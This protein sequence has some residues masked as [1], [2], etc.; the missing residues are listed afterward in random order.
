MALT[1][2]T[3]MTS[4]ILSATILIAVAVQ[5]SE[6]AT[7][8]EVTVSTLEELRSAVE[9][10]ATNEMDDV[11]TVV[12][13]T[14][15][16][17]EG[18]TYV[19]ELQESEAYGLTIASDGGQVVLDGAGIAQVLN[20]A[21]SS[22]FSFTLKDVTVANG[23]EVLGAG[24]AIFDV[25]S[26]R[27][28]GVRFEN[29]AG[30][31]VYIYGDYSKGEQVEIIDSHFEGNTGKP[32]F[33]QDGYYSPLVIANSMFVN[34]EGAILAH[35][36]YSNASIFNSIFINNTDEGSVESVSI[37][38]G[39]QERKAVYNSLF[40]EQLAE[41]AAQ[42]SVTALRFRSSTQNQVLNSV[43]LADAQVVSD[44]LIEVQNSYLD[45]TAIQG[46]AFKK[47][48]MFAGAEPDFI[49]AT[50]FNFDLGADSD[51]IDSGLSV[52]ALIATDIVG[53]TRISG[54]SVDIGPYES[55]EVRL[56]FFDGS[57]DLPEGPLEVATTQELRAAINR[58]IAN[59]QDDTIV[60]A[61][62]TYDIT[63]DGLGTIQFIDN[64]PFKMTFKAAEPGMAILDGAGAS[65]VF[66][67]IST[68]DTFL[69]MDGLTIRNG[70]SED[71]VAG[72]LLNV[73]N[74]HLNNMR[75]ED[76]IG[77]ALYANGDYGRGETI[78][79]SGSSFSGNT[80][81]TAFTHVG[82]GSPLV[83]ENS[84][85]EDNEGAV[86]A[87]V[88]YSSAY[89]TN[90][91]FKNNAVGSV[92]ALSIDGGSSETKAIYNSLFL[93]SA[94]ER[95]VAVRFQGT[96]KNK[97]FNS[98]FLGQAGITSVG[99]IFELQHSFIDASMVEGD[100]F[101]KGLVFS[102]E[103]A[104]VS[105]DSE[106]ALAT[107]SILIDNG[108]LA[109]LDLPT[110]DFNGEP[111]Q[112]GDF[113][114]IGPI[115]SS[116]ATGGDRDDDLKTFETAILVSTV[117]EL[118][119][120][121][122]D[123]AANGQDDTILLADGVY[124]IAEDSLGVLEHIDNEAQSL[125]MRSEN[126]RGAILDAGGAS[127]VLSFNS[128]E[129]STVILD[130]LV[131]K[132]GANSDRVGGVFLNV[133]YATIANS[134]FLNNEGGAVY[135][136][137]DY[138]RGETLHFEGNRVEA[139]T[140][141]AAVINNGYY[142]VLTVDRSVFESNYGAVEADVN[143]APASVKNS[144][145]VDNTAGGE[146][147]SLYLRGGKRTVSNSLFLEN[148][149][150]DVVPSSATIVYRGNDNHLFANNVVLGDVT[151][152]GN[153]GD[154]AV[155]ANY[156]NPENVLQVGSSENNIF[157]GITL[158]FANQSAKDFSL[159][160]DSGLIDQG[161]SDVVSEGD[162]DIAMLPRLSGESADIGPF[163]W[164]A[165]T[166]INSAFPLSWDDGVDADGD[167]LPARWEQRYGLSDTEQGDYATDP[168][169]DGL[170]NL[171][172][173][174]RGT[175]PTRVD[176]DGDGVLD[177]ADDYPLNSVEGLD[178]DNDG[179]PDAD[180]ADDDNDQVIDEND[181]ESL[182]PAFGFLSA[183]LTQPTVSFDP[184]LTSENLRLLDN[185][186]TLFAK[187]PGLGE[188]G[189]SMTSAVLASGKHYWEVT[190]Q[191]GPDT[192]GSISGITWADS[193][194]ESSDKNWSIW[195]DGS[196]MS[197]GEAILESGREDT[198]GG[199]IYMLAYDADTGQIFAGKN[200]VWANSGSPATGT[201]PSAVDIPN[202]SRPYHY[203]QSRECE[204][205]PVTYNF[206]DRSFLYAVPEGYFYGACPSA[207]CDF[208]G[209][210]A[211]DTSDA[212][213]ENPAASL[214]S[215]GDGAPDAW[216]ESATEEQ[217]S[218]SGLSL[219]AFPN[220]PNE[221][222]DADGDGVGANVDQ[223][224]NDPTV[225]KAPDGTFTV[226]SAS[227]VLDE[228]FAIT[229]SVEGIEGLN[230]IDATV[231]FDQSVL[232][233]VSVSKGADISD[234]NF[235]SFEPEA[236]LVNVSTFTVTDL[237]G[238]GELI[239]LE[240]KL[241]ANLS[242]PS[243]ISLPQLLLN[244]GD[245]LGEVN[246]GLVSQR[247]VHSISGQVNYWSDDQQAVPASVLLNE[248]L[249]TSSDAS[250]GSFSIEEVAAGEQT[251]SLSISESENRAIRAY[252]ASLVLG[253]AVGAIEVTDAIL[254]VAD[255]DSSGS[256]NSVDAR[257]I[258][259]YVVGLDELPF[260]GPGKIWVTDPES[261]V[262]ESLTSDVTGADFV[263]TLVGDVSGNWEPASVEVAGKGVS[264]AL[265]P[266]STSNSLVVTE[267]VEVAAQTFDVT[268]SLL[269]QGDYS[270]V[271]L[272]VSL[273]D[274]ASASIE[275]SESLL[276]D[277]WVTSIDSSAGITTFAG[278]RF[279][280]GTVS[281]ILRLR[282]S[283]TDDAQ[284]ISSLQLVLDED[285]YDS[286][287]V[288]SLV[289]PGA[290]SD[291]DGVADE[292]DLFPDD[293][294][295][296]SDYDE[297]GLG[298][299]AD[300]DDDNDG[301]ADSVDLCPRQ[302]GLLEASG[303]EDTLLD[304]ARF[305]FCAV[306]VDGVPT[307]Q[308]TIELSS[309]FTGDSLQLLFWLE[310]EDQTWITIN[311]DPDTGLFTRSLTLHP[312]AAGGIYAVRAVRLFDQDGLEVRLNEGQLNELGID[313]KSELINP[314]ED[315]VK[316]QLDSFVSDGWEIGDDDIPRLDVDLVASDIGSG[317]Q[318][319]V[320]VELIS[321]SGA[322]IQEDAYFDEAGTATVAF[323]V[324][325][326]SASG[327]YRVNTVRIYDEAGN[328]TFS[329]DWLSQNPQ[330]FT[331]DNPLSDST[332]ATLTDFNLSASFDND[333]DRPVINVS[334]VATDDVAGVE[335]V[336]LRLNRPGGG[337][338]DKWLAERQS[339]LTLEFARNI[340]L[341]TQFTPGE[342]SVNYLR[343]Q[344]AAKNESTLGASEI[345]EII[346]GGSSI[347]VYFPSEE[348]VTGGKTYVEGTS[349]D[350]FV[351]GS[352]ASDDTLVSGSGD[353]EIYSGDGDDEVDAGDGD[354]TIVGGSGRGDDVYHGGNGFDS[355]IYASA[356]AP[357]LVDLERAFADGSDIGADQL[358]SIEAVLGGQNTDVLRGNDASNALLGDMGDDYLFGTPGSDEL[359][360]QLGADSYV[361]SAS[362]QSNVST[363]DTLRFDA[364]DRVILNSELIDSLAVV[365]IE[366]EAASLTDAVAA[367]VGDQ[368]YQES[369]V[370][371]A[372][373]Y[374]A[375]NEQTTSWLLV[376]TAQDETLNGLL[377]KLEGADV[378][379][380]ELKS[381]EDTDS[382]GLPDLL[383]LDDDGDGLSDR[384]EE[385]IGSDPKSI[386]SDGDG[387]TDD[388]EVGLGSSPISSDT[389]GDGYSDGDEK[390]AGTSLTDA[391]DTP[392]ASG[393]R[394]YLIK[395]AID[396][397]SESAAKQDSRQ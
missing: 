121:L 106:Y 296:W 192:L 90:S 17:L 302:N 383:S 314:N 347:N 286:D 228:T 54:N 173:Y 330:V 110:T 301:L 66:E 5:A 324:S 351:F 44:V 161:Q 122:R 95:E 298:D 213:P 13:G 369:A 1:S 371:F 201:N 221:D 311:R 341:T 272:Q 38:G 263:A 239:V 316:P 186:L 214:D 198:V 85:F 281:Q 189:G 355:V 332:S 260:S 28:D 199:D 190:Y 55:S 177:S 335:S 312:Q 292:N 209:D 6:E 132:N 234:W 374:S 293:P 100:A 141:R 219:D 346:E 114:D 93:E 84:L 283:T 43:F 381:L 160:G 343:L 11:I 69:V 267:I 167:G 175:D 372:W 244:G 384:E 318:P 41:D 294:N 354:D 68:T 195:S 373:Q 350:D 135:S 307:M 81:Q 37:S 21:A 326:Y 360:G 2:L 10:S 34:N 152:T 3:R 65:R 112:I 253:M 49:D 58:V 206:G 139:T 379:P 162:V 63:E 256:V 101:K 242:S 226:S 42:E 146:R 364:Q 367:I 278:S 264:D 382:D 246:N 138:G 33:R 259:R 205:Q 365:D 348:E 98:V 88:Y 257:F 262:Y 331:L 57:D 317:L 289:A 310:G 78:R 385:A 397:A 266:M 18:D 291:G 370:Y 151:I 24:G 268:F 130:G 12:A 154:V 27:L 329:Q 40:Y 25:K 182:N 56:S 76:N 334:G 378:L 26:L 183:S 107:D 147:A 271:E 184:N 158:G 231:G 392:S 129:D 337:N 308:F 71:R 116:V 52:D 375:S 357:I 148:L 99:E 140:G 134:V 91:I 159:M 50:N 342:Y 120:A 363:Y 387:L 48:L 97:V 166:I 133:R 60:L 249:S 377:L 224:D 74:T 4:K 269:D 8:N 223:D 204:I 248:V 35:V 203:G 80:G 216:S 241:I 64:E 247:T 157:D 115:E 275:E 288:I 394:L 328:K 273:S 29:N 315:T 73:K 188:A 287:A 145:F 254:P 321:P 230:T 59:G 359:E 300:S 62:G 227:V 83:I 128:T 313:T 390:L 280:A 125:T 218:Q 7:L 136:Y 232:E 23:V 193:L 207:D 349:K 309:N 104:G 143:Y 150:E 240:F 366:V 282:I 72:L 87:H 181:V 77:G 274:G 179:I 176:S 361:Y 67:A 82:Y 386:D 319:R 325:Q 103:G 14:Y 233:L 197:D 164:P 358:S 222:T 79:I 169:G 388:E 236:G 196:R 202:N 137:G 117:S 389:D 142:S 276:S 322:G 340:A 96:Q 303:N 155:N 163:E 15:T 352:N 277:E 126:P 279:P 255:V 156:V 395:A 102:S 376:N 333:S 237:T 127:R 295:E 191:C 356:N 94:D 200:G 211:I 212:Y 261:Y 327:D 250:D 92:P 265:T 393:I 345:D 124:A 30:G 258:L 53:A 46:D 320:I 165:A 61:N 171:E 123:T 297:D 144:I 36:N 149:S 323:E 270:A 251:L 86:R 210:G 32:A 22:N 353:D 344:D 16:A 391:N 172:E 180:D 220:D 75:F 336:Y 39:S 187:A 45:A 108:A 306:L 362:S 396:A 113:I 170:T 118:R 9:L 380:L 89:I 252:D 105:L 31:A 51:F 229:I 338:I 245:L 185:G 70:S 285:I 339:S 153:D 238:S 243:E 284:E 20:V 111:R 290:D 208:D 304:I 19:L 174:E 215:D 119:D 305:E 194:S 368:G 168:D 47:N 109:N 235:Q 299:N 217:I 131:I 225:G 178:T